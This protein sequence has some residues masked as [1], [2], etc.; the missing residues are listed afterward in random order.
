M[1][2]EYLYIDSTLIK[3]TLKGIDGV[4]KAYSVASLHSHRQ[5]LKHLS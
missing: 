1:R 3:F 5:P 4:S 2:A